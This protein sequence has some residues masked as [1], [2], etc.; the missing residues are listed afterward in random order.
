MVLVTEEI[1]M[2]IKDVALDIYYQTLP[3][4]TPE[5]VVTRVLTIMVALGVAF[6]ILVTLL[7]VGRIIV[8]RRHHIRLM[9]M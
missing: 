8:V 2:L 9:G 5:K 7:L 1:L 3:F 4:D 6:T